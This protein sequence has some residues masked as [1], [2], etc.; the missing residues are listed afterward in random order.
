M[1]TIRTPTAISQP[2]LIGF[3]ATLKTPHAVFEMSSSGPA[4][5]SNAS[6]EG[7]YGRIAWP[8][9]LFRLG[10]DLILEQQMFLPC[11]CSD[12]AISW[13]LRG[14]LISAELSIKPHFA[15]CE[16]LGYRDHG[17]RAE[18]QENGGRL[19]WLPHVLGP[20]IVADTNGEYREEPFQ[21]ALNRSQTT[22]SPGTFEFQ[23]ARRPSILMFSS[24]TCAQSQCRQHFG[25]FLAGLLDQSAGTI[26][27]S[28]KSGIGES[29]R[30][31]DKM[32]L[33]LSKAVQIGKIKVL[34][35]S[36]FPRRED[37]TSLDH[38]TAN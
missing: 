31:N 21:F 33:I 28:A 13:Q 6:V 12:V 16:P 29:I 9:A 15:G 37:G 7:L 36:H 38:I 35:K 22:V 8:R 10:S 2:T 27:V 14:N 18:L 17:F 32:R 3:E 34:V 20:K 11:D 19:C 24:D 26:D 30:L 23:L 4:V 5:E 25:M 1:I